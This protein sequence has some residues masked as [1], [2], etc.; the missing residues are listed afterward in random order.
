MLGRGQ[1]LK[2]VGWDTQ[3]CDA[4]KWSCFPWDLLSY[5]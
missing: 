2:L 3:I 5:L 4:R 1:I